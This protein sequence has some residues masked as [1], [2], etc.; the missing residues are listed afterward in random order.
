[1]KGLCPHCRTVVEFDHKVVGI[2]TFERIC[3]NCHEVQDNVNVWF[4]GNGKRIESASIR[5]KATG[6]IY[7]GM[8]HYIIMQS[9]DE[10]CNRLIADCHT[11]AI[12]QGFITDAGDYIDREEALK[13]AVACGQVKMENKVGNKYMLF[14]EDIV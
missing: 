2:A 5:V 10:D 9:V 13:I 11:D 8:R 12:D 3:P 7:I 4:K 1:M 14:S 6:R